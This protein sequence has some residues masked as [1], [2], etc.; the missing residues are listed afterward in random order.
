[1]LPAFYL[2]RQTSLDSTQAVH[3]NLGLMDQ[4][5]VNDACLH[6]LEGLAVARI[7]RGPPPK[8]IMGVLGRM[9][10]DADN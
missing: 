6:H 7:L 1:M 9:V 4:I 5:I 10:I 2:H 8:K 3:F